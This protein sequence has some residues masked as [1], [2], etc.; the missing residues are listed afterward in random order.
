MHKEGGL[1]HRN[2][3]KDKLR[4]LTF[5]DSCFANCA[6][7]ETQLG[8]V[9]LLPNDTNYASLRAYGCHKCKRVVRFVLSG[10]TYSLADCADIA[11]AIRHDWKD[12]VGYL[13]PITM[14]IDSESPFKVSVRSTPITTEKRLM[15]DGRHTRELFERNEISD[16]D[17]VRSGQSIAD[18]LAR[19]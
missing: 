18:G 12:I 17:W 8:F 11:Y 3:R 1:L 10:E 15:I 6:D 5:S 7:L 14:L 2:L 13:I 19:G 9:I 16:V 4:T